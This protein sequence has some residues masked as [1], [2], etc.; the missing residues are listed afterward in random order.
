MRTRAV[1]CAWSDVGSPGSQAAS[2][3]TC[4]VLRPRRAVWTL[5]FTRPHVLPSAFATASAPGIRIFARLNGWPVCSSTDASPPPSRATA[6]GSR[7]MWLATPSSYR[8]CTDYS[9]P[10]SRRTAKDSVRYQLKSIERS[11]KGKCVPSIDSK[12]AGRVQAL[13]R[14]D[15]V[16]ASA[17][18]PTA[19]AETCPTLPVASFRFRRKLSVGT[20]S[21]LRNVMPF[22][23]LHSPVE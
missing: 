9:L 20:W 21:S 18:T 1:C 3:H 22:D 2:F 23:L 19:E 12:L 4:Q 15:L 8:T 13:P 14:T 6:H 16:S 7:P 17:M 11:S 10:I 5:A